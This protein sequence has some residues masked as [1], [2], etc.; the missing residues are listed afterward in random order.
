VFLSQEAQIIHQ[1]TTLEVS[2]EELYASQVK[3][4]ES[5]ERLIE[6]QTII[7]LSPQ[8]KSFFILSKSFSIFIVFNLSAFASNKKLTSLEEEKLSIE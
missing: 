8:E 4:R 3:S 1:P 6:S 7:F 2:Q 5:F